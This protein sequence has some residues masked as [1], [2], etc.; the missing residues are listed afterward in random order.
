MI[1][2]L[3]LLICVGIFILGIYFFVQGYLETENCYIECNT[4]YFVYGFIS[5]GISLVLAY[6]PIIM[7]KRESIRFFRRDRKGKKKSVV[8][9][10][11]STNHAE[12]VKWTKLSPTTTLVS[13]WKSNRS[14][15]SDFMK[16][17]YERRKQQKKRR[18]AGVVLLKEI[19]EDEYHIFLV[20]SYNN[21]WGVPK[22]GIKDGETEQ[23]AAEREFS[24]ET[25]TCVDL[26]DCEKVT[27]KS[28]GKTYYYFKK[29][30][31]SDFKIKTRP[32][33]DIEITHYGWYK[34]Y[35][36]SDKT[37]NF[38]M[39]ELNNLTRDIICNIYN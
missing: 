8:R 30:V 4:D 12:P 23:E 35:E 38:W 1:C 9:A 22:G 25:G 39:D 5:I 15:T 36:I 2:V 3:T 18:G 28:N 10:M 14:Y 20:K 37:Q 27:L 33:D 26:T 29:F 24:E 7:N 21:K 16:G 17:L 11:C 13:G 6:I 31:D 19:N 32:I 34:L